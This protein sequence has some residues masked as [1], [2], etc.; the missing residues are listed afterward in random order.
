M[1]L[2]LLEILKEEIKEQVGLGMWG[3]DPQTQAAY[4]YTTEKPIDIEDLG[5]VDISNNPLPNRESL[6]PN[7]DACLEHVL[8]KPQ[9]SGKWSTIGGKAVRNIGTTSSP[10]EHAL[11]NA[12]DFH[13]KQGVGDPVMQ[14]LADY[15]V[16]NASSLSVKNVI[17]NKKIWNSPRGWHDYS[18]T[19]IGGSPHTDHVHVDFIR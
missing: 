5:K 6:T 7:A 9:F 16:S 14:E 11:G 15:L 19:S 12:L 17:Y 4:D 3:E 10:S 1:K 8:S 13:G 18:W 2:G